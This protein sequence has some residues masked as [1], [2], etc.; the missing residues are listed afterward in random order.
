MPNNL[1]IEEFANLSEKEKQYALKIL[2]EYSNSGK[3]ESYQKLL[4][5]DYDEI[6]VDIETF[7][8]DEKYL[9]RGLTDDEGRFTVFPYWVDSLKK[10]FP[11]NLDTA[12]NT[13][14]LTGPIGIGKSL[15]AVIA[16][17]YLLYRTLCLK[18]PYLHYGLQPIDTITFSFMNV[19]IEAAKGVAWD[20]CQ[21]LLQSSPWFMQRGFLTKS[22]YPIWKPNKGIELIT[23]SRNNHIIGRCLDG[24]TT[25]LT[26]NGYEKIE[27]LVN[28]DICV[29]SVD[30]NGNKTSSNHCTVLPTTILN[31]EYE[32]EL[33]DG[34]IIKCTPEH[35]FMLKDGSYKEAKDLT[36][37]DE[38]IDIKV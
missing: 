27:D 38:L 12:Y 29:I 16:G 14:I 30:N 9:G 18:D 24:K 23:G 28:K 17:L 3:S 21:Q 2:S 31:E 34:T 35:R 8:R 13:L 20:K 5:E 26:T 10:L 6:P 7:L 36:E 25:I 33:E 19:T 32:I 22:Q 37:N 1:N 11:N 15:D 4:Y